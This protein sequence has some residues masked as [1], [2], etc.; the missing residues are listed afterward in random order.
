MLFFVFDF[1]AFKYDMLGA[2]VLLFIVLGAF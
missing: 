1:L 2:D